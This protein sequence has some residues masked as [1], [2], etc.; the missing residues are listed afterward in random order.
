M[1]SQRANQLVEAGLWLRLS[2]DDEGATRLFEQALSLEPENARAKQLLAA[3]S[4]SRPPPQEIP[5]APQPAASSNGWGPQSELVIPSSQGRD[6]FDLVSK[7]P[8]IP[9]AV[10]PP[11]SPPSEVAS[12]LQ[13]AKDLMDLDD[14]SGAMDL[15]ARAQTQA[16]NHPELERL[17]STSEARLWSHFESRLGRLDR[18][19]R[20]AIKADEVIWL[21]LDHRAGF[22][23]AQIDG[24]VSLEDVFALS[25]MSRIDTGRV[26]VQLLEQQIIRVE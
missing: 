21:G 23:L 3:R 1:S 12:L 13:G 10:I 24:T 4:G 18:R 25:G 26:L 2:G 17:R 11:E 7:P 19:P 16:P 9:L 5:R 14:H 22:I 6:A 15:L 20:V 8:K